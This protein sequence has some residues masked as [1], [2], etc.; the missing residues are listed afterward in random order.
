MITVLLTPEQKADKIKSICEKYLKLTNK[1][2]VPVDEFDHLCDCSNEML[3]E[4][5]N[6]IDVRLSLLDSLQS[7]EERLRKHFEKGK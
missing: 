6:Q 4:V 1:E 3:F 7:F 5:E 2:Y